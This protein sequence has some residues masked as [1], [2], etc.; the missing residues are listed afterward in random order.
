MGARGMR[1]L[2]VDDVPQNRRLL[3][4]QLELE[5]VEVLDAGNGLEA[6]QVLRAHALDGVVCDILMPEMDGFRLCLELRRD[7]QFA[8]LPFILYTSTYNSPT[9]RKLA[10]NVGADAYLT[11]PAPTAAILTALREAA[12]LRQRADPAALPAPPD[13]GYVLRQYNEALVNKLEEKNAELQASELF[14]RAS[15]DALSSRILILDQHGVVVAVNQAWRDFA[16]HCSTG[17]ATLREGDDH[18]AACDVAAA[19]GD[20]VAAR[21]A[22]G[23]RG[24]LAGQQDSMALE[25]ACTTTTGEHWFIARFSLFR[26]ATRDRVVAAH[27][28]ISERM[29]AEA[30]IRAANEGLEQRVAQ[31]THQ[32]LQANRDLEVVNREL[33]SFVNFAS[34]DLRAPLRAIQGFSAILLDHHAQ[35]MPPEAQ[36]CVEMLRKGGQRM[37]SLLD[38][39][40]SFARTAL[41]PLERLPVNLDALVRQCLREDFAAEMASRQIT[42]KIGPLPTCLADSAL[43][44]QV[45]SNLLGNAIKYTRRQP[46]AMIEVGSRRQDGVDVIYVKDNGAG[47]DMAQKHRLFGVFQ[48]LHRPDEFEG[49]G[50]G[51]AL[52]QR[53]VSRHGG[54]IWAES[55]PGQG[56]LF[57]LTLD[58]AAAE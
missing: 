17:L 53:I 25:Y 16:Q 14:Y 2:I 15:L 32:L 8:G 48:R 3:R 38:D 23:L 11:K 18:L 21:M 35:A 28:D 30:Q 40:L 46:E 45:F 7:P 10:V 22:A 5:G 31:R 50:V 13:E 19:A 36:R 24:M 39:L 1:L 56:A 34:H 51:L 26:R 49:T 44:R 12:A 54:R 20:D 55:A 43:L 37:S 41:Q 42:V 58:R 57:E 52:V 6:L 9:D 27:E 47:F 33:E 4:A 29:H